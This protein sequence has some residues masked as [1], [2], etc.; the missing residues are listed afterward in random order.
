MLV[1]SY[2]GQSWPIHFRQDLLCRLGPHQRF[3]RGITL[4]HIRVN[5]RNQLGDAAE[6]AATNLFSH[7]VA[8]DAFHQIEPRT[9]R[10]GEVHV[11]ARVAREP[12]LNRGVF[13]C[14]VVV[15]DQMQGLALGNVVINQTQ[16][17]QP[18]LA[19]MAWQAGGEEGALGRQQ[20]NLGWSTSR[21]GVCRPRAHC[22]TCWRSGVVSCRDGATRMVRGSSG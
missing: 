22:V 6:Y 20:G 13:V 21:T 10:R 16:E 3:R 1:L 8:K 18:L 19:S 9:T 11:D 15:G 14:G 5:G 4:G 7:Q 2:P 17:P 12:S